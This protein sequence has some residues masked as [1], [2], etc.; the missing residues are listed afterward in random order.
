MIKEVYRLVEE[1]LVAARAAPSSMCKDCA[2]QE[3]EEV[4]E[5]MREVGYIY[6]EEIG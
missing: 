2:V 5:I 6:D 1:R 4:L 3:L